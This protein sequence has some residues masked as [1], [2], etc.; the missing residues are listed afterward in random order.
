M[1][2]VYPKFKYGEATVQN[3]KVK[4]NYGMNYL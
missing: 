2:V 1:K 3:V 4:P